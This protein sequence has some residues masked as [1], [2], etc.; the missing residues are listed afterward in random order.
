MA[1]TLTF[2]KGA[3]QTGI[4]DSLTAILATVKGVT[5]EARAALPLFTA[6]VMPL[7]AAQTQQAVN[8]THRPEVVQHY[9]EGLLA[10]PVAQGAGVALDALTAAQAE[11]IAEIQRWIKIGATLI[12]A[13]V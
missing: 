5:D 10:I 1:K 8:G 2:D 4:N 6:K 11:L 12:I 3:V 7:I 9:I 13:A